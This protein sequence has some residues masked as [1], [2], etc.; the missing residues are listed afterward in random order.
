MYKVEFI[1]Q[2]HSSCSAVSS[3]DV[4]LRI[5]KELPFLPQTGMSFVLSLV[6]AHNKKVEFVDLEI[7]SDDVVEVSYWEKDNTIK[8]YLKSDKK[9]YE[10]ASESKNFI[11]Y[12]PPKKEWKAHIKE[13]IDAGWEVR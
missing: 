10:L 6:T 8:V 7:N 9:F 12:E 4:F 5:N 13:Y 1:K 2:V 11:S 3:N